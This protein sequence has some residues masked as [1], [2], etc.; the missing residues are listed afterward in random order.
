[1]KGRLGVYEKHPY[2]AETNSIE[3]VAN[4]SVRFR[5]NGGNKQQERMIKDK[6][7]SLDRAAWFSYQG[8]DIKIANGSTIRALINP[9]K[10]SQDADD[11]ILSV[12]YEFGVGV[13]DT[14]EWENTNTHWLVLNQNL[15]EL[16]YFRGDIRRCSYEI[17]WEDDNGT[18]KTFAAITGP[19]QKSLST[20]QSHEIQ[21][22]TPNY[23]LDL[24]VPKNED[25][26]K[27]FIRYSKFYLQG[28]PTCWRVEGVNRYSDNVLQVYA[29][30]YYANETEDDI[31]NGIVGGLIPEV[32]SP[33]TTEEEYAIR[34]ETFIKPKKTY[35]YKFNGRVAAQWRV[36][37]QQPVLLEIDEAD[38]R[39][40]S[41]KWNSS[42]SGQFELY[43]GDYSK[44]II[45]ESL[46]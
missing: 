24:L 8:A 21:V 2:D 12:G 3:G 13:G 44:T 37:A 14:I 31:E 16:A 18:H 39:K 33:N 45:V 15:T 42:Y 43:Y 23:S 28:D 1:M 22:D 19:K 9:D 32:E 38:P 25:T 41:I 40:V 4:Q 46:F 5:H 17:V 20:K 35:E 7:R 10:L 27:F 11:K 26:I 34:G 29:S 36:E 30:E 6:R